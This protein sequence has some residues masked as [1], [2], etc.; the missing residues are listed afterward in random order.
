MGFDFNKGDQSKRYDG[1]TKYAYGLTGHVRLAI[2]PP[3]HVAEVF[4]RPSV[5]QDQ[6]ESD[7]W[8][9]NATAQDKRVTVAASLAPWK[10]RAWK[11]PALPSIE[12]VIP[13]ETRSES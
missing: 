5:R 7:V 13:A 10:G 4:V 9:A 12:T 11:Y 1:C 3:V 6:L 2:Y 8:V